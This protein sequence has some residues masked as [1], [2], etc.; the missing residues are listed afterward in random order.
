MWV[1]PYS[2]WTSFTPALPSF[3]WDVYSA[4]QRIKEICMELCKID[5]YGDYLAEMIE[6][7]DGESKERDLAI[8]Q[9]LQ[10]QLLTA[11]RNLE[12]QQAELRQELLDVIHQL[13]ISS[14]D[15]DTQTG[16]QEPSVTAMRDMFNDVTIHSYNNAQLEAIFDELQYTVDDLAECG[17]NVKGYA[18]VNHV[19]KEPEGLTQDLIYQ[20]Q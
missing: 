12:R 2:C 15:W 3:Y 5:S 19:L 8:K 7:V 11:V 13:Q 16:T 9:D 4:E 17:L 1:V 14:L 10:N 20:G 18:L 6:K